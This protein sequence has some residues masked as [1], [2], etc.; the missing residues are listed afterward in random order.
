MSVTLSGWLHVGTS[1]TAG[2]KPR[3][4]GDEEM[5]GRIQEDPGSRMEGKRDTVFLNHL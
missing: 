2:F 5:R 4:M 3:S 1:F